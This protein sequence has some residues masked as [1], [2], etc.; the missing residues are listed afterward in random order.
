MQQ[1][2]NTCGGKYLGFMWFSKLHKPPNVP[3]TLTQSG[4][5]PY[6]CFFQDAL[7][8]VSQCQRPGDKLPWV[9]A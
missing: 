4:F 2:E 8:S 1:V 5:P 9:L 3:G 6:F 7:I